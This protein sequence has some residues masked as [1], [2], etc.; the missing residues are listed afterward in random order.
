MLHRQSFFRFQKNINENNGFYDEN[1]EKQ[2]DKLNQFHHTFL[3][4]SASKKIDSLLQKSNSSTM[5]SK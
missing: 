3:D 5:V 4:I 2:L 1:N